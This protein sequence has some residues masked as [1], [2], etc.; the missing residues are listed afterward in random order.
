[1]NQ[2]H[3]TLV[4]GWRL[5]LAIRQP[6]AV[7]VPGDGG[8]DAYKRQSPTT[9]VPG[10]RANGV[11]V[12]EESKTRQPPNGW[13]AQRGTISNLNGTY[14]RLHTHRHP[15]HVQTAFPPPSV[16]NAS[17]H[18]PSVGNRLSETKTAAADCPI[19]RLNH[20]TT[21]DDISPIG[22]TG[23]HNQHTD[24]DLTSIPTTLRDTCNG[25]QAANS[26]S[27]YTAVRGK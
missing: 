14:P 23:R 21:C 9:Y 20:P 22:L 13:K 16:G 17:P 27:G 18:A 25:C 11:A 7:N 4:R 15:G 8:G 26:R 3:L 2:T 10:F 5:T 24:N 19:T 1:M 12:E 6:S